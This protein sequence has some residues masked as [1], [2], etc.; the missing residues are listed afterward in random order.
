[1]RKGNLIFLRYRKLHIPSDASAANVFEQLVKFMDSETG[2][3]GETSLQR[4]HCDI[5]R[6]SQNKA[7]SLTLTLIFAQ[8]GIVKKK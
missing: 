1:M 2:V 6:N 5:A 4:Q 8:H 3:N 7:F